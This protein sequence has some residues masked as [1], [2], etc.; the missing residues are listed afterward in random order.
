MSKKYPLHQLIIIKEK[1]FNQSVKVVEEKKEN[2]KNEKEKLSLAIKSRDEMLKHKNDKIEQINEEFEKGTT[3]NKIQQMKA[4]LKIV[5]A[6]LEN[7]EKKVKDQEERVRKATEEY[8]EAR[9]I[10]YGFKKALEKINLHKKLWV[11][12]NKYEEL[13][14]EALQQDEIATIR[15]VSKKKKKD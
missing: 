7:E 6:K 11:K 10:M 3:S 9:K 1:R 8:E 5:D 14:E 2:L 13:K 4:Y 12:E 15:H